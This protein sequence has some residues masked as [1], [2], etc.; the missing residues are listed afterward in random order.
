MQLI[1]A[2][3]QP[4]LPRQM[5]LHLLCLPLPHPLL[6]HAQALEVG[7]PA[8]CIVAEKSDYSLAVKGQYAIQVL[9][10]APAYEGGIRATKRTLIMCQSGVYLFPDCPQSVLDGGQ[11]SLAVLCQALQ[12]LHLSEC[13]LFL[14]RAVC[15]HLQRPNL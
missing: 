15:T 13:S 8:Q 9:L 4:A 5:L 6:L 11:F 3:Q 2:H 12:S 1:G 7:L 14:L 10:I